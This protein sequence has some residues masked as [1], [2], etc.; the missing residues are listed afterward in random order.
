MALFKNVQATKNNDVTENQANGPSLEQIE[1][2]IQSLVSRINLFNQKIERQVKAQKSSLNGLN[3][4][5]ERLEGEK[6]GVD[7]QLQQALKPLGGNPATVP[8]L[9]KQ[10]G[11][12]AEKIGAKRLQVQKVELD[13]QILE[14]TKD[15][16]SIAELVQAYKDYET[17]MFSQFINP[18]EEQALAL[19][20]QFFDV[21]KQLRSRYTMIEGTLIHLTPEII[22]NN[23]VPVHNWINAIQSKPNLLITNDDRVRELSITKTYMAE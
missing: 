20:E 18:L 21:L 4:E 11:E 8:Q 13:I 5:I 7:W 6:S 12:Y 23:P 3:S 19:K 22:G 2:N 9:Q 15:H 17:V 1:E 16:Q 10:I 14:Q